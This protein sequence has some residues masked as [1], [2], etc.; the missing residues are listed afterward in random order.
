MEKHEFLDEPCAVLCY[1]LLM[2]ALVWQPA[3]TTRHPAS[4]L[5]GS[6]PISALA[7]C[8]T[9]ARVRLLLAVWL[10]GLTLGPDPAAT[11]V[12]RRDLS[13]ASCEYSPIPSPQYPSQGPIRPSHLV[14]A[15]NLCGISV[16]QMTAL[17]RNITTRNSMQTPDIRREV[18]FRGRKS[19]FLYY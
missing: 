19:R 10:C 5:W 11:K 14:H 1:P 3:V 9:M 12:A 4:Q 16:L 15:V 13:K 2:A 18:H 8:M 6:G 7:Q 17:T